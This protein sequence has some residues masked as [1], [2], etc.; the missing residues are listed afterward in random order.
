MMTSWLRDQRRRNTSVCGP[1]WLLPHL[2]GTVPKATSPIALPEMMRSTNNTSLTGLRGVSWLSIHSLRELRKRDGVNCPVS[3]RREPP[4]WSDKSR[5]W[6]RVP[7]QRCGGKINSQPGIGYCGHRPK[8]GQDAWTLAVSGLF[9]IDLNSMCLCPSVWVVWGHCVYVMKMCMGGWCIHPAHLYSLAVRDRRMTE[10]HF[11]SSHG[12][13]NIFHGV[14]ANLK[15]LNMAW[16]G[17]NVF[18]VTVL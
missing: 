4:R 13:G 10:I 17:R 15:S 9:G 14:R 1:G 6:W 12:V 7:I 11:C 3:R 16:L 2:R 8:S 18:V 5:P